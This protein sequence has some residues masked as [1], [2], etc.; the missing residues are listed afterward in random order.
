[1]LLSSTLKCSPVCSENGQQCRP[2]PTDSQ[3]STLPVWRVRNAARITNTALAAS[4][5]SASSMAATMLLANAARTSA[6]SAVRSPAK[7]PATGIETAAHDEVTPIWRRLSPKCYLINMG[8]YLY[9]FTGT[10]YMMGQAEFDEIEDELDSDDE[11]IQL[12]SDEINQPSPENDIILPNGLIRQPVVGVFN[13][14]IGESRHAVASWI[15]SVMS[16]ANTTGDW[17]GPENYA[18]IACG[19]EDSVE[20]HLIG[21]E[22]YTSLYGRSG[23]TRI[24]FP[25]MQRGVVFDQGQTSQIVVHVSAGEFDADDTFHELIV[26]ADGCL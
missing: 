5:P 12:D 4:Y 25:H 13:P 6:S 3:G 2:R 26:M 10:Q 21:A 7:I 23:R 11:T 8:F 24:W 9:N 14:S 1:L 17:S 22:I 16:A 18:N 19:P 15:L 20:S